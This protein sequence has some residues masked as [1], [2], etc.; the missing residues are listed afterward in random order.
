MHIYQIYLQNF[1][2]YVAKQKLNG[3]Q[4]LVVSGGCMFLILTSRYVHP[5]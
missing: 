3:V 4:S 1:K 5:L 2:K